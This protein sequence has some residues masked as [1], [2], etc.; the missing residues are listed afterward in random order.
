MTTGDKSAHTPWQTIGQEPSKILDL[1]CIPT[2]FVLQNPSCMGKTVKELI[3]H[4]QERQEHLG[5]NVFHFKSILENHDQVEPS[6]YPL[7]PQ[8]VISSGGVQKSTSPPGDTQRTG[9]QGL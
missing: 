1:D 8:N 6:K 3:K 2:G 7:Q 4:L 5:V 9:L